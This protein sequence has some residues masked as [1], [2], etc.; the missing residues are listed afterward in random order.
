[1]DVRFTL[2]RTGFAMNVDLQLPDKGVTALFGPSGCGKTTFLRV[3]AGL[4]RCLDSEIRVGDEIWQSGAIWRPPHQRPLGYVFQQPT[5][6]THLSVRQNLQYGARRVRHPLSGDE[7]AKVLALLGLEPLLDRAPTGLSGGEQQRVAIARA[8]FTRPRLLLLD[9][10][11]AALDDARKHDI[12]GYLARVRTDMNVPMLFVSHSRDE[13]AR[14]A[15]YLVLM[16][17]GHITAHGPVT[18]LFSRLDLALAREPDTGVVL[19]TQVTGHDPAYGLT[20][21]AFPGGTLLVPDGRHQ[22]GQSVR[23]Q[24]QARDVSL[25]LDPPGRTSILNILPVTIDTLQAESPAQVLVR[26]RAG[27]T[28]LLARLSRRSA[29][30]LNLEPGQAAFAQVK[31]VAV[32]A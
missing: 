20:Q 25:S 5:L 30:A 29:D 21:L 14:L 10:P 13:V 22:D 6:F 12:L 24:I 26:L 32:L 28:P 31:A 9:E 8:L 23:V 17:Q 2:S 18:E 15:D 16:D 19:E 3:V 27:D 4:E 11:L 1:M 7:Q